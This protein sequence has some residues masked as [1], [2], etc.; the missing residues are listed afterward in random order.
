[1]FENLKE[2]VQTQK[3]WV[4]PQACIE[5]H[6][7]VSFVTLKMKQKQMR[8]ATSDRCVG[9]QTVSTVAGSYFYTAVKIAEC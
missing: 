4:I 3:A 2:V 5:F 8:I 9:T 7:C 1:M 6:S